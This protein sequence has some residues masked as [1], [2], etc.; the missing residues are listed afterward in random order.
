MDIWL[1]TYSRDASEHVDVYTQD[2][3]E[4]SEFM[5]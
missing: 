1:S 2:T 5:L 3:T 4:T